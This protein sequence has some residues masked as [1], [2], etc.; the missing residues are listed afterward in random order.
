MTTS[1][2]ASTNDAI[3]SEEDRK[4]RTSAPQSGSQ[5]SGGTLTVEPVKSE[6]SKKTKT[7]DYSHTEIGTKGTATFAGSALS[8]NLV[9]INL[10]HVT[11]V[12]HRYF[13]RFD[14]TLLTLLIQGIGITAGLYGKAYAYDIALRRKTTGYSSSSN[15][16]KGGIPF[17]VSTDDLK[18]GAKGALGIGV[19]TADDL[20]ARIDGGFAQFSGA[21][22]GKLTNRVNI[23]KADTV[24]IS[25][26]TNYTF[27]AGHNHNWS[28]GTTINYAEMKTL[29][30]HAKGKCQLY[31]GDFVMAYQSDTGALQPHAGAVKD[32]V[33]FDSSETA[34]A[35][36]GKA[37]PVRME[38]TETGFLLSAA[39][40]VF[41]KILP[42]GVDIV[43]GATT[44][45][46]GKDGVK[47]VG[48]VNITGEVSVNGGLSAVGLISSYVDV[49]TFKTSLNA[50]THMSN[51]P[52]KPTAIPMPS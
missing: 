36:L 45:S 29:S 37:A 35:A 42:S 6:D 50:H 8:H 9:G 15:Y 41:M 26:G 14:G 27:R 32:S 44:V 48:A 33:F 30:T 20:N 31:G 4:A 19:E 12:V 39:P 2:F 7:N 46:I 24:S 28:F 11:S 10:D 49:R 47:I 34:Y 21:V 40:D 3:N 52:G 43:V 25:R 17:I 1:N 51:G 22:L 16:W 38:M 13:G 18:S 5:Q 23:D